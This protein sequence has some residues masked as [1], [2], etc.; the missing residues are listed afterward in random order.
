MSRIL[1]FVFGLMLLLTAACGD[2]E[3]ANV[4]TDESLTAAQ[5]GETVKQA[6]PPAPQS[7][8][9]TLSAG[10][11]IAVRLQDPLDS[12]VN[13]AG[14]TFRAV[15]DQDLLVGNRVVVP[16]GS[17]V[18]GKLTYVEKSGRVKGRAAMSMQFVS[19]S[20]GSRTYPIQSEILSFEAEATKTEDAT[21]VGV[22]SG[23]G[24]AIGAIAGGGKGAAIGAAVG[25]G[26]GGATVAVTRGKELQYG[27]EHPLQFTLNQ[28]VQISLR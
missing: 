24:A 9:A 4:A 19:I 21:K 1:Y 7:R 20:V 26:A 15:V 5:S 27:P 13:Q 6:P 11:V 23:I 18:E 17:P 16:R 12:A 22:A 25:A 10:T 28:D 2:M 8:Q 3:E 14:D